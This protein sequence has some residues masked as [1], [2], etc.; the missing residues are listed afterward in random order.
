MQIT[1]E[2]GKVHEP[3]HVWPDITFDSL[4]TVPDGRKVLSCMQCGICA[5]TCPNGIYMEYPPRRIIA[6]LRNGLVDEV[7][8]SESLLS[9]VACYSCMSKCPRG[10]R[11]TEVLLPLIKEE[12][13]ARLPNVPAELQMALQNTLR[14]GNPQGTSPK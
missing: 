4:F 12:M 10:I 14:Y 1:T 5:G 3:A 11:L 2:R 8:Q 9:C 7:F 6:M 13:F